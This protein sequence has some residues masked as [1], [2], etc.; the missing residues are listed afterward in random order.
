[1]KDAYYHIE[2]EEKDKVKT[3]FEFEGK[4]YH[5]NGMVMGFKN[6]PMIFQ[7]VMNNICGE[8][9]GKWVLVYL[10]D[11]IIYAKT[12]KEHDELVRFVLGRLK[13]NNMTV[14][15]K[16]VQFAQKEIKMLGLTVNGNERVPLVMKRNEALEFPRPRN[17]DE[18]RRYSD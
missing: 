7:R 10:D 6:A 16:K 18:L 5:W 12:I 1:L 2:I 17:V 9:L 13:E 8:Y 15:L 3:A 14:N 4:V 11:I